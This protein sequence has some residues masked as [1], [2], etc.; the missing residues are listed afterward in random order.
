MSSF[1]DSTFRRSLFTKEKFA[2]RFRFMC[3]WLIEL[4]ETEGD[5]V[6]TS[7]SFVDS[8]FRRSLFTKEKFAS[9]FRFMCDWLIE[10]AET[11][12]DLVLTSGFE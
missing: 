2:S 3:D 6:L 5:L 12:G 4:A 9:R 1:V 10:L 11:E 8:T 7:S